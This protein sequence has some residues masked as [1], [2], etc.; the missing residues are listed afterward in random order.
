MKT[1]Y[2]FH[3]TLQ[4]KN[5]VLMLEKQE[6]APE[7]PTLVSCYEGGMKCK[8]SHRN[9]NQDPSLLEEDLSNRLISFKWRNSHVNQWSLAV[10]VLI[11]PCGS[12]W[13]NIQFDWELQQWLKQ[14]Q[15][16]C[17]NMP[18]VFIKPL[19]LRYLSEW[20]SAQLT[21]HYFTRATL[22]ATCMHYSCVS[23]IFT[24]SITC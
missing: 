16:H 12:D 4:H 5:I 19:P 17:K 18:I 23:T 22:A 10:L 21:S 20:I 8:M 14:E 24:L 9:L 6:V 3:Q 13:Y 11:N 2:F 15:K 1:H 7:L